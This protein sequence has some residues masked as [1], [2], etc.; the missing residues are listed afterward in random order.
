MRTRNSPWNEARTTRIEVYEEAP[1]LFP[2][3][4]L[5]SFFLQK[6]GLERKKATYDTR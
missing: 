2:E 1:P 5:A 6:R 3:R 4:V